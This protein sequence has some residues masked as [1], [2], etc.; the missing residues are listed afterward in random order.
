MTPT[1]LSVKP[2]SSNLISDAQIHFFFCL[3]LLDVP[4][5]CMITETISLSGAHLPLE[6]LPMPWQSW[7][8][9]MIAMFVGNS[10]LM[11]EPKLH[12]CLRGPQHLVLSQQR[13]ESPTG[14]PY[15]ESSFQERWK[16]HVPLSRNIRSEVQ[17]GSILSIMPL[18]MPS[19]DW[20]LIVKGCA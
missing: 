12:M 11:N 5:R 9:M 16:V 13:S 4:C 19:V 14:M 3:R 10:K 20:L 6:L 17:Y 18:Y 2:H 8:K 1:W 15:L 7:M